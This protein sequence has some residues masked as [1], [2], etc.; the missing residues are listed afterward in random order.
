[1]LRITA[2]QKGRKLATFDFLGFT[3]Y[4][5]KTRKGGFKL[6]RKTAKSKFRQ[7][8][9]ELNQW[10]KKIRNLVN[11]Q[12]WWALLTMKLTGHY[13]YYGVSG[14]MPE[15]RAFYRQVVI[16]AYKWANRRSEKKSYNWQQFNR[17]LQY[18]PL[19]QPRI[20]HLTYTL[21]S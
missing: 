5:D 8:I 15:I 11:M 3:H 9:K 21:S 17:Y 2:R 12:E 19:P 6:G 18:N 20:Y 1:M 14:N 7:K 16:L 4:C 10:L 13:R